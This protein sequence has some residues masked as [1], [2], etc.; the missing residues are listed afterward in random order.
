MGLERRHGDFWLWRQSAASEIHE[1]RCKARGE[2]V[3]ADF[4]FC[5]MLFACTQK[6]HFPL[7]RLFC[8]LGKSFPQEQGILPCT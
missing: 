3:E 6:S 5:L 2:N 4:F 7:I 8:R 1:R